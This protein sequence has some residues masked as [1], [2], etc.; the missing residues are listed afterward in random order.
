MVTRDKETADPL[1]KGKEH[2][3]AEKQTGAAMDDCR[4]KEVS[5][6]TPR[7]L[8]ARMMSDLAFWKKAKKG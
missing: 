1:G 8:L 7:Q 6:M 3:A 5:R 4:C 2:E